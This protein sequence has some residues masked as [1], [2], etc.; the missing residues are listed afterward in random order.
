MPG[1]GRQEGFE[2]GLVGVG[3]GEGAVG[4]LLH[5]HAFGE[6]QLEG[7]VDLVVGQDVGLEGD[8]VFTLFQVGEQLGLVGQQPG[9]QRDG[10]GVWVAGVVGEDDVEGVAVFEGQPVGGGA[11]QL[12]LVDEHQQAVGVLGQP[13]HAGEQVGAEAVGFVHGRASFWLC[14]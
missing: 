3:D 4:L 2:L 12:A 11:A 6:G 13:G 9:Q 7:Q 1:A 10:D 8:R 5:D 14:S